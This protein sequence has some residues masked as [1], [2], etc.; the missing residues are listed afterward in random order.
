MRHPRR[1]VS[2]APAACRA[3]EHPSA[4]TD[5][6]AYSALR[7]FDLDLPTEC[8]DEYWLHPD[9]EQVFKQ[10]PGKPS[11]IAFFNCYI[12]LHQILAFALRTIVS[13]RYLH[14]TRCAV[15]ES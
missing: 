6:L 14:V 10:P 9:P 3:L 1:G 15:S 13:T 8:D 12:R 7:S 11:S 5:L 2:T 4:R